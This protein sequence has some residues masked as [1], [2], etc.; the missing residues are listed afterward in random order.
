MPSE[1]AGSGAI[2]MADFAAL[3]LRL[4]YRFKDEY[5][6]REAL[7]HRSQALVDAANRVFN[8]QR[9]EFLGDAI[10]GAVI[11]ETMVRLFPDDPEGILSR[12]LVAL[13]N[14]DTLVKVAHALNLG[15]ALD[16]SESEERHGGR[17]LASNLEDACEAIIGAIYLDAG[18]DAAKAFV[19]RHWQTHIEGLEHLRKDPKT[20]LQEVVQAQGLPLPEYEVVSTTGPAHAPHFTIA[21]K[22]QG[23]QPVEGKGASKKLA[24]REAAAAMLEAIGAA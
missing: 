21:V 4:G 11:A 7:T 10:L 3:Q 24:E 6:L 20:E 16:I 12:K 1:K 5:L 19:L 2:L 17:A 18:H 15:E 14:G 13:V 8:N 9:L 22:V 23:M